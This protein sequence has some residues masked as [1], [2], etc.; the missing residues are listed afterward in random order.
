[1]S[2]KLIQGS[3][4]KILRTK[5]YV[6]HKRLIRVLLNHGLHTFFE[7]LF[8]WYFRFKNS[9]QRHYRQKIIGF[10][11]EVKKSI[12][13]RGKNPYLQKIKIL[14]TYLFSDA[15]SPKVFSKFLVISNGILKKR[16]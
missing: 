11:G 3:L 8:R 16:F 9:R 5:V 4:R 1:M 2:V 15:C 14:F 13:A 12:I 6:V 10:P 7:N